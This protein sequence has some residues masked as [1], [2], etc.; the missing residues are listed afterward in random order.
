[1]N[2]LTRTTVMLVIMLA[3]ALVGLFKVWVHQDVIQLGYQLSKAEKQRRTYIGELEELQVEIAAVKAPGR[4]E[5]LAKKLRLNQPSAGVVY[6][7]SLN[8]EVTNATD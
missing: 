2:R 3:P 4:L 6:G 8:K 5:S 1:M 7:A